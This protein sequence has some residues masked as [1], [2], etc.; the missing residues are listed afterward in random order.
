MHVDDAL[1]RKNIA[2]WERVYKLWFTKSKKLAYFMMLFYIKSILC[3][4][5]LNFLK[6]GKESCYIKANAGFYLKERLCSF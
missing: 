1:C 5:E 3:G 6:L 4:V 2:L